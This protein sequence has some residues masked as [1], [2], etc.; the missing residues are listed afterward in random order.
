MVDENIDPRTVD[1]VKKFSEYSEAAHKNM[2]G[3]RKQI[4][5]FNKVMNVSHTRTRDLRESLRQMQNIE[6]M[7]NVQSALEESRM[8]AMRP[9]QQ[10]DPVAPTRPATPTDTN[11]NVN[12][13]TLKI[14]VSGVTDRSDKQKLAKELSAMVSKELRTKMGGSRQNSGMNRGI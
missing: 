7:R 1:S 14:D 9:S 8:E 5:E 11:H 10:P 2:E 12:I 13:S 3:L 6:P 4:R